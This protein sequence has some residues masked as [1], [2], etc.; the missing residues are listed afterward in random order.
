[1]FENKHFSFFHDYSV[2]FLQPI[3][4]KYLILPIECFCPFNTPVQLQSVSFSLLPSTQNM[5]S[6]RTAENCHKILQALLLVVKI[7]QN[8]R[9][10]AMWSLWPGKGSSGNGLGQRFNYLQVLWGKVV[11]ALGPVTL[12][13]QK[14][15]DSAHRNSL[16]RPSFAVKTF[17]CSSCKGNK[18]IKDNVC[19]EW[20]TIRVSRLQSKREK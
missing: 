9:N 14:P 11:R 10:V 4:H 13:P 19:R 12:Q 6:A 5:K 2:N 15:T 16:V 17:D 18:R 3:L 7:T 20:S 1:M 8:L